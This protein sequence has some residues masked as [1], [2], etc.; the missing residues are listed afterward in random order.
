LAAAERLAFNIPPHFQIE[1]GEC[2]SITTK[3]LA[4]VQR[5][6]RAARKGRT[7]MFLACRRT[8]EGEFIVGVL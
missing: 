6:A 2:D 3:N 4:Q 5:Y 8:D 7:A 1:I